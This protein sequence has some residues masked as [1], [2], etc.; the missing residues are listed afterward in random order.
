MSYL[1]NYKNWRAIHEAALFEA[2]DSSL[3]QTGIG[4]GL[5]AVLK[6][7]AIYDISDGSVTPEWGWLDPAKSGLF[8]E[9]LSDT[10]GF[11][12]IPTLYITAGN[13]RAGWGASSSKSKDSDALMDVFKLLICGIGRYHGIENFG[14]QMVEGTDGK[15]AVT[16]L[17]EM[18][19][20]VTQEGE[21]QMY[22]PSSGVINA[23]AKIEEDGT[24]L[25]STNP[26]NKNRASATFNY[27]NTF[28]LINFAEGNSQQYV[29]LV[30]CLDNNKVLQLGTG[31]KGVSVSETALYLYSPKTGSV[32]AASME[33]VTTTTQGKAGLNDSVNL[34]FTPNEF[35]TAT[36]AK[37][38]VMP[39]DETN[40]QIQDVANKILAALGEDQQI[41]KMTLV[42]GAS[43]DWQGLPVPDSNGSGD[44]SG[45]KLNDANFKSE[46]TALGN[47]WLAWR[48]GRQFAN[49]LEKLLGAKRIAAGALTIEWK[50][51]KGGAQDGRNLAYSVASTGVAPKDTTETVF[52]GASYKTGGAANTF[53]RYKFTWNYAN[54]A[55]SEGGWLK[56]IF[57]KQTKASGDVAVGETITY[58]AMVADGDGGFEI[59]MSKRPEKKTGTVT[60][61]V[62]GIPY[63]LSESGKELKIGADRFLYGGTQEK[64]GTVGKE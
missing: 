40:A 56:K 63:V 38:E 35:A 1:L 32:D 11:G 27:I 59:D 26:V 57:G 43:P 20:T 55:N 34:A 24:V 61:V 48:R 5:V 15:T 45:G 29:D 8:F 25:N 53:Y 44:P 9:T 37:N 23:S 31:A 49:V 41:T 19:L 13:F 22:G 47:Q 28:N 17:E 7:N 2:K 60:K 50:V 36:N 64:A 54:I 3:K 46:K 16:R 52:A 10:V 21:V 62:D 4:S 18:G 6:G 12:G 14:D 33:K 42:S 58:R 51:G 30:A 39:V